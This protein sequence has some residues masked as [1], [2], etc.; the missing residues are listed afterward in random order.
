MRS[1]ASCVLLAKLAISGDEV[2]AKVIE[3]ERD[4]F[5]KQ[6]LDQGKKPELVDK[7]VDGRIKK[8]L[9]ESCLLEQTF[10]K[11]PDITITKLLKKLN[12]ELDTQI[13]IDSY[14]RYQVGEGIEKKSDD[15][16]AEVAKMTN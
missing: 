3:N 16:A 4:I 2:D 5:R 8:F 9:K 10:I 13:Q 15:L 7:I 1:V 11:D 12:Q 14:I 6:A